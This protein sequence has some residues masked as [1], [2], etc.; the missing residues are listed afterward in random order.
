[1][2]YKLNKK[3][4]KEMQPYLEE[5]LSAKRDVSWTV[6]NPQKFAFDLRSA[7][8]A[9]ADPEFGL[10]QYATLLN[11]YQ[12][13]I[14]RL[15]VLAFLK[16]DAVQLDLDE[17]AKAPDS[18][19]IDAANDVLKVVGA[20]IQFKHHSTWE[21]P[22]FKDLPNIGRLVEYCDRSKYKIISTEP[23]II[24]KNNDN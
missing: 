18:I 6:D 15:T 3:I 8:K 10:T 23:L 2:G 5:L 16:A 7:I 24:T 21:F 12:F 19:T 20:L 22:N 1:M 4:I 11:K 14:R 13:K 9:S 17:H